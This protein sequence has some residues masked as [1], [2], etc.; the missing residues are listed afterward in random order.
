MARM[1]PEGKVKKAI[2]EWAKA[3]GIYYAM[4]MGTGFGSSGVPDFLLC[5]DGRF[6]GIEAK[7][8]GKR[9]NVTA[10]QSMHLEAI[11]E[12]GG[13]AIVVDDPE[14]QLPLVEAWMGR[15]GGE[16]HDARR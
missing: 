2:R 7:A 5:W 1:T 3:R 12:A 11:E 13:F 16:K 15:T 6:I 14:T 4:P 10:L 8:A 9:K